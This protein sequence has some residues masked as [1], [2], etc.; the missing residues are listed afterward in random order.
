M[1]FVELGLKP[2][3]ELVAGWVGAGRAKAASWSTAACETSVPGLFAAGDVTES[4]PPS[5]CVIAIGDGAKA[6][7]NAY[8]YLLKYEELM[9]D[10]D[11]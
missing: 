6:A 1:I 2:H 11:G 10:G 7:L 5:R 4:S 8:E 3:T 9:V